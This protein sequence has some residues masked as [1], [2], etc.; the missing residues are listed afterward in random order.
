M[1]TTKFR[2]VCVKFKN[3]LLFLPNNTCNISH[4]SIEMIHAILT[5]ASVGLRL[6]T[7]QAECKE[8]YLYLLYNLISSSLIHSTCVLTVHVSKPNYFLT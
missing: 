7:D 1:G 4:F 3:W 6:I 8:E 2:S 5:H